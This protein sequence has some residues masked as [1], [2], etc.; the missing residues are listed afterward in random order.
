[1][2]RARQSLVFVI[3]VVVMGGVA[4]LATAPADATNPT[5]RT[6]GASDWP[7]Y[8]HDAQHSFAGVTSITPASAPTLAQA[9]FFPT[10]DA[11]TADPI[12]VGDTVY[13]GSWDGYFYAIDRATGSLRW[14]YQ[15]KQ[16]PAINPSPGNSGTRR[17][18]E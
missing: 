6:I 8:G 14:K 12:V 15:L 4:V 5:P 18:H 13:V 17:R 7:T 2:A 10:G 3:V 11:V 1:M 9:W 16:Q